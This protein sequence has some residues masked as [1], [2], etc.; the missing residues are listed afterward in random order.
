MIDVFDISDLRMISLSNP[1][2]NGVSPEKEAVF[3]PFINAINEIIDKIK[4]GERVYLGITN[5]ERKGSIGYVK[6]LDSYYVNHRPRITHYYDTWGGGRTHVRIEDGTIPCTLGWE[7]RRNKIEWLMTRDTV[8]LPDY[9]GPT[10]WKKFDKKAAAKA[11]LVKNPVKDRDGNRLAVGDRVLYINA[12]Y[13]AG[14]CLDRGTIRE[15]KAH[16]TVYGEQ[17]YTKIHVI[18]DNDAGVESDIRKAQLSI[19]KIPSES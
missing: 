14:A 19:L 10:V 18:I 16:T 1:A 2:P 15:I 11:A 7:G 8:Y 6:F 17:T 13:G 9:S 4:R 5:G 3:R 12:R